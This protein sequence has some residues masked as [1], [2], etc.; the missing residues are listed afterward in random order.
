MRRK[1]LVVDNNPVI[2]KFM[3]DFLEKRN[4]EVLTATNGLEALDTLTTFVPD[5]MFID[6]IMP[7]I[8]GEKLCRIVSSKPE[9]KNIFLVILSAAATEEKIDIEKIGAHACIAKGPF[10]STAKHIATILDQLHLKDLSELPKNILGND[11]VFQRQVTKELLSVNRHTEIIFNNMFEGVIEFTKET[12]IIYISSTASSLIGIPEEKLLSTNF[13]EIFPPDQRGKIQTLLDN[14][15][16]SAGVT[17]ENFQTALDGRHIELRLFPIQDNEQKSYIAVIHDITK[18]KKAEEELKESEERY[19]DLFENS[20]DLIQ[21]IMMD[22]GFLYVN[23]AWLETLGYNREEIAD[24]SI[25]DIIHPD[26]TAHC[27]EMFKCVMSGEK[28]DNIETVF[29]AK[30]GRE[31]IVEGNVNCKFMNGQPFSTRGIFRDITER[32]QLEAKLYEASITD[33]LTGLL[34]RRGF[35]A[36]AEKIFHN[37]ERENCE[38]FLLYLDLDN[39]KLINDNFGHNIG[40]RALVETAS[41][42]NNTFRQ[43]DVIGRVGGDEFIVLYTDKIGKDNLQSLL[44]RLE[45]NLKNLNAQ[46]DHDYD[47]S[48]SYGTVKYNPDNKCSFGELISRADE[49]MY[50]QK[51]ESK[52]FSLTL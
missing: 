24:L 45:K 20:T 22:G 49:L 7:Q 26:K 33:E 38:L 8:N 10:K 30:D 39:L 47:V 4:H 2:L 23:R 6:L 11:E 3:T 17:N 42:L 13:I 34:N 46:E 43:A 52:E 32:K 51:K 41:V 21:C 28:I 50:K 25:F 48:L 1:I 14:F 31:I 36:I 9:Y 35:F 15:N 5:I 12:K 44:G 16:S 27:R 19:R 18:R 40:D 37:A 29:V